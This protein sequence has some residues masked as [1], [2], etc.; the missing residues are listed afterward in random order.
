MA[1]DTSL[2]PLRAD[3]RH[4]VPDLP[5][6]EEI[7]EDA[8]RQRLAA[9]YLY[10]G[11]LG[12]VI[13][14]EDLTPARWPPEVAEPMQR[15]GL[16][17]LAPRTSRGLDAQLTPAEQVTRRSRGRELEFAQLLVNLI[18]HGAF[19]PLCGRADRVRLAGPTDGRGLELELLRGDS[20]VR[21]C[22][23]RDHWELVAQYLAGAPLGGPAADARAAG[24]AGGSRQAATWLKTSGLG[25]AVSLGT[26]LAVHLEPLSAAA[27]LGTKLVETRIQ[28]GKG[29]AET[30]RRLGEQL[31]TL[32]AQ[33]NDE[34][35][36]LRTEK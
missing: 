32:R 13:G 33:A 28:A 2:G 16:G 31:R 30:L 35:A 11:L 8:G 36:D 9:Y 18:N 14:D 4:R 22:A 24:A 15:L 23:V 26:T 3:A 25:H 17:R 34:V 1:T 10:T 7:L 20:V 29:Q 27:G 5:P 19:G 6:I 12:G 21:T